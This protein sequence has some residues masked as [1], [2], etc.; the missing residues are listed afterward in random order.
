MREYLDDFCTIYL[1]DILIYSKTEAEH[2]VH[3]NRILQKL[4]E[5]GL[6]ADIT[7]SEFH[8]T[9]VLYLRLIITTEGVRMDP[10]K[11]DTIV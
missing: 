2:E 11:V 7:K 5:V 10:S 8:I 9:Q 1:N 6:Q 4:R 3:V